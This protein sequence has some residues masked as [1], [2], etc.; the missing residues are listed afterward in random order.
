MVI[1]NYVRIFLAASSTR[2]EKDEKR[3]DE[4]NES[5]PARDR[6]HAFSLQNSCNNVYET[7]LVRYQMQ[8]IFN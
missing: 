5:R 8:M 6:R 4:K 2:K 3:S 7:N 1:G